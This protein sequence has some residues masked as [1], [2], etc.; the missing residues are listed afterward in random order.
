[1]KHVNNTILYQDVLSGM[2]D[3]FGEE[4]RSVILFGSYARGDYDEESDVDIAVLVSCSRID[5]EKY[6]PDIVK[7]MSNLTLKYGVLVSIIDIP[8]EN[9]LEYKDTLPFYR[10]ISREGVSLNA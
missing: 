5:L 3:I 7:E 8:E 10:T 1:M 9:F 2:K 4:L 6:H